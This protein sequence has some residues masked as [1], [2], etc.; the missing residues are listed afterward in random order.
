M[1]RGH[2]HLLVEVVNLIAKF[3]YGNLSHEFV[4]A[5]FDHLVYQVKAFLVGDAY[6]LEQPFFI[7]ERH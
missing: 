5:H 2:S 1:Q 3:V 4:V 7:K 6:Q